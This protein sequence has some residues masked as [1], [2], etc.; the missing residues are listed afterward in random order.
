MTFIPGERGLW[1]NIARQGLYSG[2]QSGT[3]GEKSSGFES[4]QIFDHL[5]ARTKDDPVPLPCGQCMCTVFPGDFDLQPGL[6]CGY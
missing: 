5:R 6:G 3:V 2:A 1:P 4:I